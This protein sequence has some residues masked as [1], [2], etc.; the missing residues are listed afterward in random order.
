MKTPWRLFTADWN[1]WPDN[2][3]VEQIF[4]TAARL[5]FDG[6]ELGVYAPDVE[7]SPDRIQNLQ[8]LSRRYQ[9]PIAGVL[10]SLP[11]SQ[12]RGGCLASA[13]ETVR[14]Q[15]ITDALEIA[16]RVKAFGIDLLGLWLGGDR[17]K[18]VDDYNAAWSRLIGGMCEI[19]D[20]LAAQGQRVAFEYKPGEIVANADA[21]R[22]LFDQV[23]RDNVGLL[24]DTGHAIYAH[25]NLVDVLHKC[26][27][28]LFYIHL[29]DN[30][31]DYDRDL[32]PG[33]VHNFR[34]FFEQLLAMDYR[35]DIS[36]DLYYY[37]VDEG[38]S[39]A[40]ASRA[41]REYLLPLWN[42]LAKESP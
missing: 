20:T 35:G 14:Q 32:P 7:L 22:R 16:R 41:S 4:E 18:I 21:A 34:P 26:G 10:Y 30:Y 39:G 15:V 37:M 29:D 11:P 8:E 17:M 42:S 3:S 19:A 6:I 5:E 40:Q 25:E 28:R 36:L 23:Q 13:E 1:F 2:L 33:A 31:A 27:E 12:W 9:L 24:L 38:V